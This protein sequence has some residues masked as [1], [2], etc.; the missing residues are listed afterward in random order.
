MLALSLSVGAGLAVPPMTAA[1][2]WASSDYTCS[3]DDVPGAQTDDNACFEVI[4]DNVSFVV[5]KGAT[6]LRVRLAGAG[7]GGRNGGAGGL[8]V[9][10]LAVRPGTTLALVA[11]RAGTGIPA[12]NI[13]GGAPGGY[14]VR[15]SGGSGGG[16]TS[17][18]E[19]GTWLAAAGGGGGGAP[20][21]TGGGAGGGLT[22]NPGQVST[23]GGRGA[24]GGTQSGGGA[25][26]AGNGNNGCSYQPQPGT[27]GIGGYGGHMGTDGGGGGGGGYFGGGGGACQAAESGANSDS[28]GGG[29]SGF[30]DGPGV[31]DAGT[32][33]G[34]GSPRGQDGTLMLA[35]KLPAAGVHGMPGIRGKQ[36]GIGTPGT[37]AVVKA[38]DG[39]I[40]CTAT[41]G[42]DGKFNCQNTYDLSRDDFQRLTVETV[43]PD[44]PSAP[45][46]VGSYA[47]TLPGYGGK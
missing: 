22:G 35:F 12:W 46:P 37:E 34:A 38:P 47:D 31:T 20:G 32:I 40:V 43:D 27:Q 23:S 9:A 45:Y 29:G 8:T 14:G 11:G 10:T 19:N 28:G 42:A 44:S 2:A 7:G 13:G 30:I 5:P 26:G 16:A 17:I 39:R 15:F 36:H 1:P 41:V 33:T 6:Q 4:N 3:P 24:G 25:P 18:T 21:G